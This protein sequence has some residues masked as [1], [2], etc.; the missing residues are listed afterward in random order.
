MKLVFIVRYKQRWPATAVIVADRN[1]LAAVGNA[2][3]IAGDSGLH[4][5]LDKAEFAGSASVLIKQVACGVVGNEDVGLAVV[6]QVGNDNSQSFVWLD[7]RFP[8]Y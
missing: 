3:L 6:V 8:G 4:A 1:A 2:S 5:D 7:S